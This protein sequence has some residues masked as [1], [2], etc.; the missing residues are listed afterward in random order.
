MLPDKYAHYFHA[1]IV[2]FGTVYAHI[3]GK[4]QTTTYLILGLIMV[5]SCKNS[6]QWV[7]NFKPTLFTLGFAIVL[8]LTGVSMM[9][10]VSEFLYFNF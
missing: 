10:R 4:S 6:M 1:G 8:F 7:K 3:E 2:Q 5:L 9:S